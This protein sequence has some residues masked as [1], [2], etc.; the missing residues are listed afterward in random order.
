MREYI[1]CNLNP[2][3][4]RTGDCVVRAFAFFFGV[5]WTKAFF[6]V[7]M[8]CA[9][10]GVVSFNYRKT[11]Y[12]YLQEKGY[13]KRVL[14]F[15]PKISVGEFCEKIAEEGKTYLIQVPRHMTIV[16]NCDVY[17]TWDCRKEKVDYY[18]VRDGGDML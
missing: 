7:I 14:P 16:C 10:N 9:E 1:Y 8:F 4:K 11:Y 6:D 13:V 15:K 12:K 17:D 5:S 2:K 18:W 3:K